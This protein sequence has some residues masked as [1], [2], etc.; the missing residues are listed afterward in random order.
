VARARRTRTP[1][2]GREPVIVKTNETG[3]LLADDHGV[4]QIPTLTVDPGDETGAGDVFLAALAIRR[5]EGAGWESATRFANAANVLSFAATGLTLP[6]REQV[7]RTVDDIDGQ[8][9]DSSPR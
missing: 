5:L 9:T 3:A 1:R 8:T 4:V 7:D 2:R 6:A